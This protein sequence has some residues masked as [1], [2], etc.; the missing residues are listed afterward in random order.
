[1]TDVAEKGPLLPRMLAAMDRWHASDLFV[2]E[3][4]AP[5]ARVDG[6]VRVLPL[7]PTT[8][9]ELEQFLAETASDAERARFEKTG[10]L[11]IGR[12]LEDGRR[13]RFNVSR[14]K[15]GLAFVARALTM[16]E[17]S[18]EDLGLPPVLA[19]F[20]EALRGLFLVTGATGSGKSTTLAAMVHHINRTRSAHVV[21]IED[22][23][24]FLHSDLRSSVT[25]REIGS[26]TESFASA[27]RH[28]VRQSPDVIL[29]GEMRDA[30]TMSVAISAALTG[31][32][33]LASLHTVDATQTLQR[34]LAYFPEDA[35]A[36]VALDLSMCLLGVASQRLLPRADG[37]GRVVAVELLRMTP[38]VARLVREQRVDE[39]VDAMRSSDD[40]GSVTFNR[41]LLDLYRRGAVTYDVGRAYAT[42]PDEFALSAQ[43]I[44][45][46]V[47]AFRGE[48][49][50]DG[51]GLDMKALLRLVLERGASDLH[52][53]VGRPPIL[54]IAGRLEP[55]PLTELSSGDMR[56]LLF[57][58]LNVR[59]RSIYE[60]EREI[61][62]AL[63]LEDGR[64]FRINAYYQKGH[65][66]A[67]LRAIPAH[68]PDPD[69][70][71]LPQAVR[72]L[73]RRPQGLLLV[74]GPTGSGKTTTLACLVDQINRSRACRI[75]TV[76]DP[77]EYLHESALATVD[78]REVYADTESFSAALKFVLRQDP[79]VIMVGEMR[80]L[81][82][83]AAA[84]T[85]AETGHLVLGTLHTNDAISSIDRIVD[86]FPPHQQSQIRSQLAAA[87][88]AVV[89][90]RLL[91]RKGA[92]GRVPVFEVMV[93]NPAIR[94]LIRES[95]MHQALGSME[96]SRT[97]GMVT[98]DYA[99]KQLVEQGQIEVEEAL[100]YARNAK[101]F[102]EVQVRG[103]GPGE[104]I[105][106]R[107]Y[108]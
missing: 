105:A 24:E 82:T 71:C 7:P 56:L 29:I 64:R 92:D 52:L 22:P 47:A 9:E 66:A 58:V 76:E 37:K 38:G 55:L 35:R 34:I 23:I 75:L 46:G 21:T 28:V 85:A 70:L 45:S 40:T 8:R 57:S 88:L 90:Q 30:E 69:A 86:V 81:E 72:E 79:D 68:V 83:I 2:S 12:S 19:P 43:G 4:K 73:S 41:A 13:F 14:Q 96:T 59:Q 78:Q 20:A 49:A 101:A 18:F 103:A 99:L 15:G 10:D 100:R 25:Q 33:V 67:A 5:R 77:I 11:D 54:R 63:S 51:V 44:E 84:L 65:M 36:Q 108:R 102:V 87:L 97:E 48:G 61:D 95:K 106:E 53:T 62:F 26:D 89:S 91:P 74:V 39:V 16:G 17:L 1:M 107:P 98:M 42:N 32:L 94:N 50:G 93:A 80:D 60:L 3:G 6:E 27:L 104:P 31:H